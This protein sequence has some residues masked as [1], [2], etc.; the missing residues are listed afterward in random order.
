MITVGTKYTHTIMGI[1]RT[2]LERALVVHKLWECCAIPAVLYSIE[3][4]VS[5]A[6]IGKRD[7]IQHQ[8]T[9]LQLP[10]SSSRVCSYVDAGF[11]P[12]QARID[13]RSIM[14][15]WKVLNGKRSPIL[16]YLM[17]TVLLDSQDPWTAQL[18]KLCGESGLDLLNNRS[19]VVPKH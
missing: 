11:K 7:C 13:A 19:S 17:K 3:A 2:G 18:L 6:Y 1:T 8:V 15:A 12:I 10:T 9:I 5:K 14:F 16:K 4:S